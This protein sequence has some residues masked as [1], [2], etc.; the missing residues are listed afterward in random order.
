[1]IYKMLKPAVEKVPAVEVKIKKALRTSVSMYFNE[2]KPGRDY[3]LREGEIGYINPNIEHQILENEELV[4]IFFD[5]WSFDLFRENE[6]TI[7]Q[8][9]NIEMPVSTDKVGTSFCFS[10]QKTEEEKEKLYENYVKER[11]KLDEELKKQHIAR[12][13]SIEHAF[14][15]LKY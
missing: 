14:F 4:P 7:V 8:K 13:K 6:Y 9:V 1:M 15:G 10:L 5:R 11:E 3:F 12:V 2:H